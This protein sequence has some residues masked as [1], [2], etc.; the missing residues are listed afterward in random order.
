MARAATGA[1]DPKELYREWVDWLDTGI[2]PDAF[3]T[4]LMPN[5]AVAESERHDQQQRRDPAFYIRLLTKRAE[6]ILWGP[7]TQRIKVQEHR[8]LWI[9]VREVEL[10]HGANGE[11]GRFLQYHLLLRLPARPMRCERDGLL[12]AED[13]IAR[14]LDALLQATQMTPD[15]FATGGPLDSLRTE[16]GVSTA[17]IQVKLYERRHATYVFKKLKRAGTSTDRNPS[18]F[19]RAEFVILPN[20]LRPPASLSTLVAPHRQGELTE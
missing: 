20:S 17:D 7:S 9:G 16:N 5:I 14:V 18:T 2:C 15:A 13:R 8:C 10:A 19:A 12:P 3:V 1:S 6:R 4:I 11:R